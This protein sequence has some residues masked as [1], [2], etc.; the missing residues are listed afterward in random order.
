MGCGLVVGL[1]AVHRP[2]TIKTDLTKHD[3]SPECPPN[4]DCTLSFDTD[5]DPDDDGCG[6]APCRAMEKHGVEC[7]V[8]T[9]IHGMTVI[10]LVT[11]DAVWA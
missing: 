7:A 9:T 2:G 5:I 3:S 11:K 10:K 4:L 1:V 8:Y 6:E